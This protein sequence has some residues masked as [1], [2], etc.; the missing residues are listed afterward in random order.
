M[1]AVDES[2][3]GAVLRIVTTLGETIEGT[4]FAYDKASKM[5]VLQQTAT[6]DGKASCRLVQTA[7]LKELEVRVPPPSSPAG[8]KIK[9]PKTQV[10]LV[11]DREQRAIAKAEEDAAFI[12]EGVTVRTQA[13]FDALR[14]TMPCEWKGQ[15][16]L[17]L[18][19]VRIPPPYLPSD[20]H[21]GGAALQRVRKVLTGVLEKIDK[22]LR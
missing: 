5:L 21:G 9:L 14:K 7:F 11:R 16:I 22:T 18:H 4:M 12:G 17:V 20:C 13:I 19:E 3:L 2:M 15:D 8:D 1:A 10:Q 6:G